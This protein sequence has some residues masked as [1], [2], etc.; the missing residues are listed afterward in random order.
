MKKYI[1]LL[2]ILSYLFNS[3]VSNKKLKDLEK[4]KGV[5]VKVE[6]NKPAPAPPTTESSDS[7]ASYNNS[8]GEA[9]PPEKEVV[10]TSVREERFIERE[11]NGSGVYRPAPTKV[12]IASG[13]SS[14][15]QVIPND[16]MTIGDVVYRIPDTMVVF[17]EYKVTVRIEKKTGKADITTDLGNKVTRATIQTS[18][19]MEVV[20]MDPD[21]DSSFAIK[22]TNS[23]EQIVDTFGYTEWTWTVKPLRHGRKTL[24]LVISVVRGDNV[25]QKV[26]SDTI[27]IKENVKGEVTTFWGKY[28]QWL[29]TTFLIPVFVYFW[30]RKKK[31]KEEA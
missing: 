25:K 12:K 5:V 10:T 15:L 6:Q 31:D 21:P 7:F 1:I 2:V 17:K 29:F 4:K 27:H 11:S 3:C 8:Y 24:N 30:K 13:V 16:E 28:W 20:L 9:P 18:S 14:G 23:D 26:Y 19:M 22:K